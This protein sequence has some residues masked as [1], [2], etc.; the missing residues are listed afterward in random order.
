MTLVITPKTT[1]IEVD[2][3]SSMTM[4]VKTSLFQSFY[5]KFHYVKVNTTSSNKWKRKTKPSDVQ[6][7]FFHEEHLA[8]GRNSE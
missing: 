3:I 2:F 5:S 6:N 8:I 7:F 1:G 4:R